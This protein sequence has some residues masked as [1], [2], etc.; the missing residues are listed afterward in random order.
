MDRSQVP[1]G[2][3]WIP[4][5]QKAEWEQNCCAKYYHAVLCSHCYLQLHTIILFED[6]RLSGFFILPLEVALMRMR[7]PH[8]CPSERFESL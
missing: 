4:F 3:F 8:K 7:A 6:A 5:P 2:S 1:D